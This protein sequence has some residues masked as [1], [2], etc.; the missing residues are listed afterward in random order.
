MVIGGTFDCAVCKHF[1]IY[2]ST[3]KI[4]ENT[5]SLGTGAVISTIIF[6]IIE[7]ISKG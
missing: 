3:L 5:V 2:D 6:I 4:L 7:R 1:L